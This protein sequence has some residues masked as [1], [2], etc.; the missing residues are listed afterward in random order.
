MPHPTIVAATLAAVLDRDPR[1]LYNE[2]QLAG[3]TGMKPADV[4]AG[5]RVGVAEATIKAAG[6]GYYRGSAQR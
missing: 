5:L 6:G 4:R 1:A 2:A 3:A